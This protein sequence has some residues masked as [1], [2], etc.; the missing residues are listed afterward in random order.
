MCVRTT[1]SAV[2]DTGGCAAMQ[3]PDG[4]SR[5]AARREGTQFQI[6]SFLK[7]KRPSSELWKPLVHYSCHLTAPDQ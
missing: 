1:L 3:I 2:A 6:T 4:H 7:P 5:E